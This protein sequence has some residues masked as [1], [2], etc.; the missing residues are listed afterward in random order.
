MA[1]LR[2]LCPGPRMRPRRPRSLLEAA[3]SG[4]SAG[5]WTKATAN[6]NEA[7]YAAASE[8][9]IVVY[10]KKLACEAERFQE[11]QE[12]L[13]RHRLDAANSAAANADAGRRMK[14]AHHEALGRANEKLRE[15]KAVMKQYVEYV[16]ARYDEVMDIED[17]RHDREM[18]NIATGQAKDYESIVKALAEM[19]GQKAILQRRNKDMAEEI[20]QWKDELA[21]SKEEVREREETLAKMRRAS[22]PKDK[23]PGTFHSNT[24][25]KPLDTCGRG[26]RLSSHQRRQ[27]MTSNAKT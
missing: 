4:L 6:E 27:C 17:V 21:A 9:L 25:R 14:M 7:E 16:H 13:E 26:S 23:S 18:A 10:E 1:M 2:R 3:Q 12:A 19:R 20:M 22:G 5:P 11:V 8:E 15:E 24:D